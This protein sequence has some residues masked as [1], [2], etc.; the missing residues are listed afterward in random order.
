MGH[1]LSIVKRQTTMDMRT[2]VEDLGQQ[3]NMAL[4]TIAFRDGTL[5]TTAHD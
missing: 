3:N 4:E 5:N 2:F 1:L